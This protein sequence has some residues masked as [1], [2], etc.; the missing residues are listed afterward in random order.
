MIIQVLW[1]N[2]CEI[3]YIQLGGN[4]MINRFEYIDIKYPSTDEIRKYRMNLKLTDTEAK[5]IV[6]PNLHNEMIELSNKVGY[7]YSVLGSHRNNSRTASEIER[8]N[9]MKNTEYKR[10]ARFVISKDGR[11]W[12][13]NTHWTISY[14]LIDKNSRII[15]I[16]SYVVDFREQ[17]PKIISINNSVYDSII[18]IQNAIESAY[19]IQERL[20]KGWRPSTISFTILDLMKELFDNIIEVQD[21]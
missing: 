5:H 17:F 9:N 2:I 14:A 11:V 7:E 19:A 20:K 1:Y 3:F 10:P 4:N 15:D 12:A 16:P 21:K 18:C 8:I 6:F 13:D